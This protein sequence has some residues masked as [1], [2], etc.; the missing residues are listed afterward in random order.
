MITG[1]KVDEVNTRIKEV[2][3]AADLMLE[4]VR[5]AHAL[6][7]DAKEVWCDPATPRDADRLLT[8]LNYL[9]ERVEAVRFL[10]DVP[11][12]D[13]DEAKA[14]SALLFAEAS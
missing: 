13:S 6:W 11:P 10:A 8:V 14:W 5:K 2:D 1:A 9:L 7:Q 4:T 12:E 3:Y